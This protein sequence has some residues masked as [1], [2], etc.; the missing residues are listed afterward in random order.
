M[1]LIN[2]PKTKSSILINPLS[3]WS[4]CIFFTIKNVPKYKF[5]NVFIIQDKEYSGDENRRLLL[6]E[7]YI[8]QYEQVKIIS[9]FQEI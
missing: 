3:K 7:D 8:H 9:S 2:L 1:N 5:G 4:F 6:P